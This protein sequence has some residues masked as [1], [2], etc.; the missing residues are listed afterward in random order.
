MISLLFLFHQVQGGRRD[1]GCAIEGVPGPAY[2]K[3]QQVRS[4]LCKDATTGA[5]SGA[6]HTAGFYSTMVTVLPT[7]TNRQLLKIRRDR[8]EEAGIKVGRVRHG[9][10]ANDFGHAAA[11]PPPPPNLSVV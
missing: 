3:S 7:P 4:I 1:C 2:R 6:L 8:V 10:R 11:A 9:R 5:S